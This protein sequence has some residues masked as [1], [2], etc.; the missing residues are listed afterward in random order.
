[1]ASE[2]IYT[3][4]YVARGDI[5]VAR[6]VMPDA[7]YDKGALQATA[8]ARTLGVTG[9]G[10]HDPPG[11]LGSTHGLIAR[12]GKSFKF[13][14][15]GCAEILLEAG[16]GGYARFDYLKPDADGKAVRA[17]PGDLAGAYA[18]TS[19]SANGM[20]KVNVIEPTIVQGA[21]VAGPQ[22]YV[23]VGTTPYTVT[24]A[25]DGTI[26]YTTIADV[27]FNL[28]ATQAGLWYRFVNG[29]LSAGTGLSISPAAAD[30]LIGNG[31][32]PAD[33]K[34]AI[35]SGATDALNDAAEVLGNGT[36]GWSFIVV[37]GTWAREA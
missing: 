16:S 13:F 29:A 36:T 20:G 30:Q 18:L 12:I 24:A 25:Q 10:Q 2:F 22:A 19:V 4:S 33:N 37:K 5:Y 9:P 7:T 6:F 34:D 26:F 3:P 31:F 27:V 17:N 32:T 21:G 15:P 14:G 23:E 11:L 28:P 35:N 8:G 1:M